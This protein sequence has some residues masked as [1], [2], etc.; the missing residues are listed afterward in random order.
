MK[1]VIGIHGVPRSG[2]SWLAQ[3][4]NASEQV[5]LKFQPLF[6]YAF[7]DYLSISSTQIE[8]DRFFNE[9]YKSNDNFI[10]MRDGKLLK[11]Y[12]VFNKVET[13][14]TLVFKHVRY[15]N[16]LEHILQ[17]HSEV[18]FIFI[19]RNPLAVLSSWKNAPREFNESWAFH[20]EWRF[21]DRKNQGNLNEYFGFEKWK[22][23]ARTF[24]KLSLNFSNRVLLVNYQDL[25]DDTLNVANDCFQFCKLE[26]S[27]QVLSFLKESTSK[28]FEDPNSVFRIK[29]NDMNYLNFLPQDII[30]S[31]YEELY[32][33]ELEAY[34]PPR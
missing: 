6:S 26:M 32:G 22:E 34:L 3:I 27:D 7:K 12:P 9:I 24:H 28:N 33:T 19:I 5:S 17:T 4:I 11:N 20:E 21:A 18:K 30:E 13:P 29:K 16:L 14:S 1:N 10:N 15:H 8:I 31:V 25:L 23:A 2:T